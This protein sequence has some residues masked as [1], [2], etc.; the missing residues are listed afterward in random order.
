VT[1]PDISREYV[2]VPVRATGDDAAQLTTLPVE[3]AFMTGSAEPDTGDWET[4]EW[5]DS[6]STPTARILVG[7]TAVVLAEGT[8]RVWV[9]VTGAV[10]APV[11]SAGR[12]K[13]T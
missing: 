1:I 2:Y 4:A 13:I 5:D 12:L 3:M 10:E 7:P 9:R 6:A 11:R 8:Y